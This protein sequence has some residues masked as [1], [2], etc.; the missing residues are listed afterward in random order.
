MASFLL[1]TGSLAFDRIA[2]FK[3]TFANHILEGQVHNL[4][5]SFLVD[6]MTVNHGGTGGNI[7]YNLTLLGECPILLGTV[8]HDAEA[9][10]KEFKKRKINLSYLKKYPEL[11]TANATIMTDLADN[12][13]ASF[14]PG[15]MRK[16]DQLK[17]SDVK[18]VLSMA[19]IAPNDP[20]A[21]LSYK[22]ECIKKGIPF[23]A[24]PG[25]TIPA[26]SGSELKN[27]ITGAHILVLND[28]EW[29]LV[30]KKTEW[31]IEEVLGK[32]NFLIVTYGKEGSKIWSNKD[33]TVIDVPVYPAKELVDPTGCG[34]AYRAGLMF[35]HKH[36]MDIEKS[37][38]LGSW[39]AAKCV[40]QK[41]TQ[42][43]ILKTGDFAK[44]L[45]TLA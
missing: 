33:A 45:K 25:Q 26:F 36:G 42:N 43:H 2:V 3:D 15:A 13:I 14:Y 24:D 4:N 20:Q 8:G 17:I 39:L 5:L 11:L 1:V 16:A 37:A 7:A 31:G 29:E 6:E 23:I 9:Y 44:F 35:G 28:Y 22:E 41:G 40:E 30:H 32:V 12:Q 19:V 10:L 18:E 38:H 34:D 21:M 27:F